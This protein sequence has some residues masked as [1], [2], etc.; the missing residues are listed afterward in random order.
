M[1][2]LYLRKKL[3]RGSPLLSLGGGVGVG[4]FVLH[5]FVLCFVI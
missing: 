2:D 5:I 1:Y 4:V 3:S